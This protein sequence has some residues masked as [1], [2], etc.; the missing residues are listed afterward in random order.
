MYRAWPF[1]KAV[2]ANLQ[3]EVAKTDMGLAA[4]YASLVCEPALRNT[5]FESIRAEPARTS[6]QL[7]AML[8]RPHCWRT[9]QCC[10]AP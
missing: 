3:L 1:F 10:N 6:Q 7:C 5:I 2:L 4:R 9:C 8:E